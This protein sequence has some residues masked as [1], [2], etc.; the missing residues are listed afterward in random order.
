MSWI[1]QLAPPVAILAIAVVAIWAYE[2]GLHERI[3]GMSEDKIAEGIAESIKSQPVVMLELFVITGAYIQ[4][5]QIQ[6]PGA[7]SVGS[8]TFE[9]LRVIAGTLTICMLLLIF[10]WLE[11]VSLAGE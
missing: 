10:I 8:P 3:F 2:R 5:A 7:E 1:A 11:L 9:L 4:V 6:V